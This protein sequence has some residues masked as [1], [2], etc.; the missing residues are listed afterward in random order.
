MDHRARLSIPRSA[1]AAAL[2]ALV[3]VSWLSPVQAEEPTPQPTPVVFAQPQYLVFMERH[4]TYNGPVEDNAYWLYTSPPDGENNDHFAVPDGSGGTFHY[5]GRLIAGP[6]TDDTQL[7]PIMIDLG[8]DWLDTWPPGSYAKFVDCA[9]FRP[10]ASPTPGGGASSASPAPTATPGESPTP[11]PLL[12]G[13]QLFTGT[14]TD[15]WGHGL[16]DLLVVLRAGDARIETVTDGWGRYRIDL[17]LDATDGFDPRSDDVRVEAWTVSRQRDGSDRFRVRYDR[18]LR[19]RYVPAVVMTGPIR[20]TTETEQ[21]L[22]IDLDFGADDPAYDYTSFPSSLVP[23]TAQDDLAL[24][25]HHVHQAFALADLLKQRLD[26]LLP[27]DIETNLHQTAD[28]GRLVPMKGA[29]WVGNRSRYPEP[30]IDAYIGLG[31]DEWSAWSPNRPDNREWH[32]FGHHFLADA[33]GDA[34][35]GGTKEENHGG[36][37]ANSTSNDAWTEGFAEWY[38]TMVA[39][40]VAGVARPELYDL[41]GGTIDLEWDYRVGPSLYEEIAL[42]GVLL[43][44]E[45]GPA[46]YA[47]PRAGAK[48]RTPW[49]VETTWQGR[50][51]L[52]GTA[53]NEGKKR[54]RAVMVVAE[55]LD[56]E[57]K[58]VHRG[59]GATVPWYLDPGE[60]GV[61]AIPLPGS[62]AYA[63]VRQTAFEARANTKGS[64]DDQLDLTSEELW[65]TLVRA[66]SDHPASNYYAYDVYDVYRAVRAAYP[67]D[68]DRDGLDDV[69][70]IFINHGFFNDRNGDTKWQ[71]DEEVGRSGYPA[72]PGH[73]ARPERRDLEIPAAFRLRLRATDERGGGLS[74]DRAR[75]RLLLDGDAAGR[76]WETVAPVGA[77]GLVA[78]FPPPDGV[79]GRFEV[80]PLVEGRAPAGAVVFT[81]DEVRGRA[82][83]ALA[84]GGAAPGL[85]EASVAL[86]PADP[87]IDPAGATEGDAA[88]L[89]EWLYRSTGPGTG[90]PPA[91]TLPTEDHR[92]A[93]AGEAPPTP[94]PYPAFG[95]RMVTLAGLGAGGA[96][97]LVVFAAGLVLRRRRGRDA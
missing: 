58:V 14:V 18:G 39:K 73:P 57:G 77:D 15:G 48:V 71:P 6:F 3:G 65:W 21:P 36:L 5:T 17:V 16:P 49:S 67:G 59:Y 50:R 22:E 2:A 19:P 52:V 43:D 8:I 69:D 27:L 93:D 79:A 46:D 7:C 45:D 66:R 90:E 81:L 82:D 9:R 85:G 30:E 53:S 92:A 63:T 96:A 62:V 64:D 13:T 28:D 84:A 26:Y 20:L 86:A 29:F 51:Y 89:L 70:E 40:H 87:P 41:R 80:V 42:A 38:S 97:F 32:E 56:A 10:A 33:F 91:E 76:S 88:A 4:Q 60:T 24:I 55:L 78:L 83:V 94:R 23:M 37:Y 44:L 31:A 95:D 34:I 12:E 54:A 11:E 35:P 1:A 47:A 68:R 72:G 25:Y 61:Y 75:V 74:F